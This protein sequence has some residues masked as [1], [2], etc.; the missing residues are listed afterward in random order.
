VVSF[1]PTA[2]L[3]MVVIPEILVVNKLELPCI[4]APPYKKSEAELKLLA[5][6]SKID[7]GWLKNKLEYKFAMFL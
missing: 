2:E 5:V 7:I 3:V 1:T 4:V 6:E